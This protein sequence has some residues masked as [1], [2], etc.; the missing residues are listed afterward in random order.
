MKWI[1]GATSGT[2][3]AGGNGFGSA[4]NQL[5]GILDLFVDTSGN[6][7][8]SDFGNYRIQKWAPGATSGT[9]VAGGNGQGSAANQLSNPYGLFVDA[10]GN[11]YIADNGNNRIQ[12]WAPGATSGVTVAGGNGAGSAA[13]KLNGPNDVFVDA[14]GN[15][16]IADANNYRVQKWSSGATSGVTVAGGNGSGSAANQLNTAAGIYLDANSNV[17]IADESN[18]RIQKWAPGATSGSTVAGVNGQG[19]AANQLDYP[20]SVFLDANGNIFVADQY[21]NRVQ[22]FAINDTMTYT[23]TSAGVYTATVTTFGGAIDSTAGDTINTTIATSL[24]ISASPSNIVSAGSTVTFTAVPINGGTSPAYQWK[25]N[26]NNVG[27]NSNTYSSSSLNN[28]DVVTCVLTSSLVCALTASS[29]GINII[30]PVVSLSGTSNCPNSVL[31]VSSSINPLQIVWSLNGSVI[32]T[33]NAV[34]NANATTVAGQSSG[35][36]GSSASYLNMGGGGGVYADTGGTVYVADYN[37]NR[38]EKWMPGASS[39]ILV[40][41]GNGAGANVNQINGPSGV[42]ADAAGNVYVADAGNNRIM[43]WAPGATYGVTVAGGN[44]AG[45]GANQFNNIQNVKVDVNGNIYVPDGSNNRVQKWTPG[46]ISGITVAGQSNGSGGSAL[47]KLN[48]PEDVFIDASNNVYVADGGNNRIVKWAPGATTG[49]LVAAGNGAGAAANQLHGPTGVYVDYFN[50][51]YISDGNNNRIQ[52]WIAGATSGTT[53]GGGNGAGTNANQLHNPIDLY[54]DN[55]GD[56]YVADGSNNRIQEFTYSTSSLNYTA[57]TP[58]NYT[59]T[60]TTFSGATATTSSWTISTYASLSS[61]TTAPA[62]CNNTV[63]SYSPTSNIPGTVFNWSRASVAGISNS[64][65]NGTGNPNETLTNTSS[66][67]VTV[68]YTYSLSVS[69]CVNPTNFNVSV[70]VFPTPVLTST[71]TAPAICNNT[72]FSFTPTSS[73][74]GTTF[75]WSRAAVAGIS[76]AAASGTGNPNE[77]LVNTT[78]NP[79]VVGYIYSLSANGCTNPASYGVTVSVNPTPVLSSSTSPASSCSNADFSYAPSSTTSGASFIW[80]RAA[81]SGISNSSASGTGNPNETLINTTTN[82]VVVTYV[83]SVGI[84]GCTNPSAYN[85][86]DTVDPI[87]VLSNSST[88][89]VLCNNTVFSFTPASNVT[90][91]SFAWSRAAVS[92]ITNSAASGTGNPNETLSNNSTAPVTATY[93]YTLTAKGCSGTQNVNV[94][95]NPSPVLTSSLA[96]TFVCS[97]GTFSYTPTSSTTGTTFAW[98]RAAVSG[99][100]NAAAT[101]TGNPLETLIDTAGVAEVVTYVYTLSANGCTNP[102]TYSVIDTVSVP[103]H[104]NVQPLNQTVCAGNNATFSVSA[105]GTGAIYQWSVNTGSGFTAIN[106]GGVYSGATTNTLNINGATAGMNNYQYQCNISGECAPAISTNNVTLTVNTPPS[107]TTNPAGDIICAGSNATFSVAANGALSYQWYENQGSGFNALSSGGIYSGATSNTLTITGVPATMNAYQYL[108]V[109]SGI[110]APADTTPAVILFVN[111]LPA[112]SSQAVNATICAGNDTS[113]TISATGTGITYQWQLNSGSGFANVTNGGAYSGAT[114]NVLNIGSAPASMTGYQYKCIVTGICTPPAT[115]TTT[116]LTVNTAP[117]ITVQPSSSTI[118]AGANTG[119]SLQATGTSLIYQWQINSGSGFTNLSNSSLYNGAITASLNIVAATNSMTANQYRCLITGICTPPAI[120]DTVLLTVDSLPFIISQTGNDSICAGTN[121][122]FSVSATGTALQYQWMVNTGTGFVNV[123]NTSVYNNANTNT[124]SLTGVSAGMNGYQ[125]KCVVSGTCTPPDTSG[126]VLLTV[127]TA[128]SINSQSNNDTICAGSNTTFTLA[129]TGSGL[130]YQWQQSTGSGFTNM[131]DTGIYSGVTT[132]TLTITNAPVSVSGYQYRCV[133]SGI[134]NP[135][136]SSTP[137]T[138]IVNSLPSIATQPGSSTIC[139]G[140]NTLFDITASGTNISYQWQVNTGSG[141]SNLSNN[142]IYNGAATD[143]LFILSAP[144]SMNGYMYRCIVS[145]VCPPQAVSNAATLTVNTSPAINLQSGS[146]TICN[147]TNTSFIISATGTALN[148]QWQ[149][150]TSS[151]FSNLSNTGVYSGTTT[152]TLSIASAPDSVSGK[153]YRCSVSGT[154]TPSLFSNMDTL[155]VNDSITFITQPLSSSTICSGTNTLFS[156]NVSGSVLSYQWQV[157]M[158]SGFMNII[159]GGIYSGATT[160]SLLLSNTTTALNGYQY[161]CVL[162]GPCTPNIVSNTASLTVNPLPPAIITASGALTFC[163][164]DSVTLSANAGAG[165]T[166]QW[167]RNNANILG[168]LNESYTTSIPGNYTVIVTNSYNCSVT[169]A[170]TTVSNYPSPTAIITPSGPTTFCSNDSIALHISTGGGSSYQWQY[171]GVN[172]YQATDSVLTTNISGSY[173]A[174]VTNTYGC[175]SLSGPM[176]ITVNYVPIPPLFVEMGNLIFCDGD[177]VLLGTNANYVSYQWQINN[178]NIP[179]AS[180][181]Q[182]MVHTAGSYAV[183]ITTTLCT[184]SSSADT[185]VVLPLPIDSLI[186]NGPPI[187]CSG[188][189]SYMLEA[190]QV[191]GQTYQ[192]YKNG[193]EIYGADSS[194]YSV[195]SVDGYTVRISTAQGCSLFTPQVNVGYAVSP[196][197]VITAQGLTL[198]TGTYLSY[199]WYKNN[200]SIPSANNQN[201]TVN[202]NGEYSVSVTDSN[203]CAGISALYNINDLGVSPISI[204]SFD[205]HIYPNPSASIVYIDAPVHVNVSVV[206]VLGKGIL[207]KDNAKFIDLSGLANG[208]YMIKVYDENNILLKTEKL[209]KNSW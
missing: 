97:N 82:E 88:S 150:Q 32:Q 54:F 84:N 87:P 46:A 30:I 68:V 102:A 169:S 204:S 173:A 8:V 16:Y 202:Q 34:W 51:I 112:V 203:G 135:T 206:N 152:N 17:Y 170:S 209:I 40:A 113:F 45:S 44:G 201:Y 89:A 74:S 188:V 111:L 43:K 19:S 191:P 33:T 208:A 190:Y 59:A 172:I 12:K 167:Q 57:T 171:V 42:Y 159:N 136:V 91:T 73:T 124:L 137:S 53:I 177:S 3:V 6:I 2:V 130:N 163:P 5:N 165:L 79:I 75:A 72:V 61:A 138:L 168:A 180:N 158:G 151:G 36:S 183:I 189:G 174:S 120:S 101:G 69:G 56:M 147:N 196:T 184:A 71:T 139:A 28:G 110:C 127:H 100:S 1:S 200:V 31:T 162:S 94:T 29:N 154:C 26:G 95:V 27:T 108:C 24:V 80:S 66:N 92:G 55:K 47:T 153:V 18:S 109:V 181:N 103:P 132:N 128:P 65:A 10:S 126:M 187:I 13:N 93:V 39:G 140:A 179:G 23:A 123:S 182:Y 105:S 50:N 145:G 178:T 90:G 119:F 125:Y 198:S 11:I 49:V 176:T 99:I 115:S 107:V 96:P 63:F 155:T 85:V 86:T 114:T 21:N 186:F 205:V 106:N 157:N 133:V 81:V 48:D 129:T 104:I 118:C 161:R 122:S 15:V 197:P 52:K 142:S 83:Y 64:A 207:Q 22:K 4:S 192:W 20:Y 156:F 35:T 41:G 9:T 164:S 58:G 148:Y 185:A 141:Y 143:S 131:S 77:T 7:Y 25:V 146:E 37:N 62:I 98:S 67:P 144:A 60:I 134:C 38:I 166:Y 160:A 199:Q 76:N 78:A 70:T 116:T 117:F 14:V 175:T 195:T 194:A 193:L 149:E 121:T